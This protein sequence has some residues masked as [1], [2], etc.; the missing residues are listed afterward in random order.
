VID[1][2]RSF[3]LIADTIAELRNRIDELDRRIAALE[4]ALGKA[5][6]PKRVKGKRGRTKW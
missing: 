1:L 2:V 4:L 6:L 5:Q 3:D